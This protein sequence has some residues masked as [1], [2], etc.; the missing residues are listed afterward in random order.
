MISP[1]SILS[2]VILVVLDLSNQHLNLNQSQL[3][4]YLFFNLNHGLRRPNNYF[5]QHIFICF[6]FLIIPPFFIQILKKKSQMV[7]R[8]TLQSGINI[9]PTFIN[10]GFFSRHYGLIIGPTFIFFYISLHIL[11]SRICQISQALCL[12]F[13]TNFPGPTF[14]SCP[15]FILDSRVPRLIIYILIHQSL[16]VCLVCSIF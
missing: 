16:S 7:L 13:L 11:F 15:T 5:F 10:F 1:L 12:F 9:G 3:C 2:R 8:Y 4:R 6:V 14:I